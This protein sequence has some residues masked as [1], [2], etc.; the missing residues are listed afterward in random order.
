MSN[1]KKNM[2]KKRIMAC[3]L[4][5]SNAFLAG[6]SGDA[7]LGGTDGVA[8]DE[9]TQKVA[10]LL[11]GA[12]AGIKSGIWNFSE[13]WYTFCINY[14]RWACVII[15]LSIL[16]GIILYDVFKKNREIQRWALSVLSI[17]VPCITF[18]MVYVFGFLYTALSASGGAASGRATE[19]AQRVAWVLESVHIGLK[20]RLLYFPELWYGFCINYSVISCVIMVLSVLAGVILCEV[21]KKNTEVQRWARSK[22]IF[23][24]PV[25]VFVMV[26]VYRFLYAAL[27]L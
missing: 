23:R 24:I 14:D 8:V 13:F 11:E 27:C 21:F 9:Q 16:V 2:N 3:L 19:R 17:R 4:S 7:L 25:V 22:L 15:V 20:D 12:D 6:C 26:P 5:V 10:E 1:R 18:I